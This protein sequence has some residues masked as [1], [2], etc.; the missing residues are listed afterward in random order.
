MST[1]LRERD[2]AAARQVV[3]EARPLF[4]RFDNALREAVE[5]NGRSAAELSARISGL[6][7]SGR[8]TAF[9]LDALSL[10]L[11]IAAGYVVVRVTRRYLASL[12]ARMSD[13]EQ[14]AGRVAHDVRGP[15][16]SV[17]LAIGLAKR[18][19]KG[20]ASILPMMERA[21]RTVQRVSQLVDG[22]LVFARSGASPRETAH[23]DARAVLEGVTEE[24]MPAAQE[25]EIDL[26]LER[27]DPCLLGCSPGVLVS[28]LSNLMANAIKYMGNSPLRQ[29][30]VRVLD[31]GAMARIEVEDTGPGIPEAMRE[32]IFSPYVRAAEASIPG[33]GLGLATVRRLV[34]GHG[35][36]V[37]L[38]SKASGSLF[39]F[40][41]PKVK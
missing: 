2:P 38:E 30:T 19:G 27:V 18:S 29:V 4:Y 8:V 11:A 35:G 22:L 14:F 26:R 5:R 12:A 28:L 3:V 37:G 21:T 36:A 41:L 9:T 25:K 24:M 23:A 34:D 10:L 17:S 16:T 32:R 33:L 7:A 40:E 1:A 31:Q 6:A 20:D 13:L 39:W 15:L